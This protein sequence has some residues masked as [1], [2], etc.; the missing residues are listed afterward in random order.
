MYNVELNT[1]VMIEVTVIIVCVFSDKMGWTK[2]SKFG[3]A[4]LSFVS[5]NPKCVNLRVGDQ[6]HI[7][8]VN[9]SGWCHGTVINTNESGIFPS[10]YVKTK[11]IYLFACAND[12]TSFQ[13]VCLHRS[14]RQQP[15]S[16]CYIGAQRLG[17]M[18]QRVLLGMYRSVP[19]YVQRKEYKKFYDAKELIDRLL[20]LRRELVLKSGD[21]AGIDKATEAKIH[22]HLREGRLLME[23]DLITCDNKGAALLEKNTSIMSLLSLVWVY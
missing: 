18:H 11:G 6:V 13:W 15:F 9:D 3:V 23:L 5:D 7:L 22:D 20:V 2:A 21:G 8:H 1:M 14:D 16:T 10:S 4:I 12:D 19:A 17:I